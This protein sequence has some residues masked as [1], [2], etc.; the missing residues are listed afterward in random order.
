MKNCE[1]LGGSMKMN[2][3]RVYNTRIHQIENIFKTHTH[4]GKRLLL[5]WLEYSSAFDS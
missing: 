1:T 4:M 3:K 2:L 5:F